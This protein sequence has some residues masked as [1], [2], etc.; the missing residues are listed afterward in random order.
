MPTA[1]IKIPPMPERTGVTFSTTTKQQLC[2]RIEYN[3]AVDK[4]VR[5]IAAKRN[6]ST[7]IYCINDLAGFAL[8]DAYNALRQSPLYKREV[9]KWAN[10]AM[11]GFKIYEQSLFSEL[12][13]KKRIQIYLDMADNY[14]SV[15]QPHIDKLRFSILAVLTRL[16]VP[17]RNV[18]SYIATAQGM[19]ATS[20]VWFDDYFN[21]QRKMYGVDLRKQYRFA[22]L[23]DIRKKWDFV[24]RAVV[25]DDLAK[26][27]GMS[28]DFQLAGEIVA[29]KGQDRAM[30]NECAKKAFEKNNLDP[31]EI[32][33]E[34]DL[35]LEKYL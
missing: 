25:S 20:A 28:H 31:D 16:N 2:K 6:M 15:M 9:K 26:E 19:L 23:Q 13:D 8:F 11:K 14:Q 22:D 32:A 17:H 29:K 33:K 1:S 10:L 7:I 5:T 35:K 18:I 27:V 24:T 21:L 34:L 4:V 12:P 3:M 30:L